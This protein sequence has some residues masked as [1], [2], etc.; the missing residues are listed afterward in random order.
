[1]DDAPRQGIFGAF[2]QLSDAA[3]VESLLADFKVGA[4]KKL[5]LEI[6]DGEA[7][8]VRGLRKAPIAKRLTSGHSPARGKQLSRRIIVKVGHRTVSKIEIK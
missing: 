3:A 1:M 2:V 5:R 8:G 4:E 7:D 6:F